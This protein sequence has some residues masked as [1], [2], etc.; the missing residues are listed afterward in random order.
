VS[1]LICYPGLEERFRTVR[2]L[3]TILLGTPSGDLDLPGLY[4]AYQQFNRSLRSAPPA[5]NV[6]GM[7]HLFASR[8]IIR[9]VDFQQAEMQLLTLLDAI[10]DSIDRDPK[11]GGRINSGMA[12]CSDGITGLAEI[13][14]VTYRIVD[15]TIACVDKREGT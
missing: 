3:R 9:W 12:Y 11:L 2:G 13:G 6:T 15:Y 8:L 7:T 1:A 5:R 4:T 10:P 14:G